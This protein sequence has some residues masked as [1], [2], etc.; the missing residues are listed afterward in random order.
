MQQNLIPAEER[1]LSKWLIH[2][3]ASGYT[4]Y[5]QIL[6]KMAEGLQKLC[7]FKINDMSS[8]LVTYNPLGHNWVQYYLLC[9]PILYTTIAYSIEAYCIK[10][11]RKDKII[12]QFEVFN[13]IFE[14]YQIIVE[15]IYNMDEMGFPIGTTQVA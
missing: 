12:E 6:Q 7:V 15:N 8:E 5:H 2:L 3:I 13:N 10:E 14:E 11:V 9:H 4:A 1:A